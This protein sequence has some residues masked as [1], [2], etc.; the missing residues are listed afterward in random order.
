MV[1][2]DRIDENE[3]AFPAKT[4]QDKAWRAMFHRKEPYSATLFRIVFDMKAFQLYELLKPEF[5]Q[6]DSLP[7]IL[8]TGPSKILTSVST[9]F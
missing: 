1:V 8:P 5:A 7:R 9:A 6:C 2:A 4:R 3:A